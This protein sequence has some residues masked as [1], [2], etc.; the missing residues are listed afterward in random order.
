MQRSV[1]TLLLVLPIACNGGGTSSGT[2]TETGTGPGTGTGTTTESTGGETPTTG[3][4]SPPVTTT[5]ATASEPTSGDPTTGPTSTTATTDGPDTTTAATTDDSTTGEPAGDVY[6]PDEDGPWQYDDLAG[7]IDVDGEAI[8]VTAHYPTSGPEEGPYPVVLLAHG[9]NLPPTQYTNY[10]TRLASHGYVVV[11]VDHAGYL[12]GPV[13]HVANANQLLAG[14]DW[15]AG[16]PEL[17]PISDVDNAGATGHS[18]GGKISVLAAMY[19]AR[20]KAAITLDPIDGANMCPNMQACPDVSGLLPIA[21]PLGFLGETLD[22]AGFMACAPAA[23]NF[24]TFYA[25]AGPP[26]LQ[27][28]VNGA[29]HM[30]FLDDVAS[31]GITC[32]FCQMPTLENAVVNELARAYVVAYYGR[33]LRGN[34]GYDTYLTGAEAQ[35]RYVDPGLVTIA[36]K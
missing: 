23:E 36:E 26:A 35:Q 2:G 10:A 19:D 27:V 1:I 13:D 9:F 3:T 22:T 6:D 12:F 29:N 7:E 18:L 20:I 31:C 30:S 16:H 14:L 15:A 28:T 25:E 32:S 17:G 24:T 33:Y 4:T 21:I 11:N 5:T 8:G 34:A